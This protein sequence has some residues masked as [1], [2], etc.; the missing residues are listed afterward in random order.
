MGRRKGRRYDNEPKLNIKKVIA[1][2]LV[3][4][5]I[6]MFVI[7]IKKLLNSEDKEYTKNI[8]TSYFSVF[9]NNKWGV[10]DS[11]GKTVINPIYEEMIIV[12]NHKKAVFIVLDTVDYETKTYKTI[13]LDEK[14]KM[15]FTEYEL[16]EAIDNYD[17]NNNLWY[18]ENVLKVKKEG[19]YGL[20][21]YTGKEIL[22]CT[23][24]DIYSLKGTSNSLIIKKDNLLGL[25]DCR[26]NI[27]IDTKYTNILA[28]SK[29]YTA[30]YIVV[31]NEKKYGLIDFN[32]TVILE[33]KYQD[34]KNITANNMYVV[35]EN[36]NYK[37]IDKSQNVILENINGEIKEINGENIVVVRDG[38]YVIINKAGADI[39]TVQYDDLKNAYDDYYIA[40][41]DNKYGIIKATGEEVLGFSYE[42]LIYRDD[43]DFFEGDNGAVETDI[44]SREFKVVLKGIV[45]GV[46]SENGYF[47][48]RINDEYK[49]YNLKFEEKKNTDVLI[50]NTLF[51]IKQDGKYG[52]TDKNG[53]I[54]VECEYDDG[55]EQ[56]EFGYVA[57]KSNGV[58]GA[59]DFAGK[60]VVEPKYSLTNNLIID[61]INKWHIGE[62]LNMNYYTDEI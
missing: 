18:E 25:V 37:I 56:N 55:T 16:V 29:D 47:R 48:L 40:K 35:K 62:D 23:Y 50:N 24:D 19:K 39:N 8:A 61:F 34:I 6:V 53:N 11:S 43:V 38:K 14:N 52:Y 5:V 15:L 22:P 59:L 32:K 51:L 2:I 60:T 49:Y 1:V 26:G 57:V 7:A 46:N 13:V 36:D 21:D 42:G 9:S 27:I 12:P 28:V 30:G 20:I 17:E 41:K 10:I 45:T 44:I 58:W 33:P 4:A 31:D 3:I 54:V